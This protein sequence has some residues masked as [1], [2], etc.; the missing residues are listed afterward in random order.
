RRLN[1]I[2][3]SA[4]G[5]TGPMSGLSAWSHS[6]VEASDVGR[7][8]TTVKPLA[9]GVGSVNRPRPTWPRP[10]REPPLLR[11][12]AS[13]VGEAGGEHVARDPHH[14][15]AVEPPATARR[16]ATCPGRQRSGL[17][18]ERRGA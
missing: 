5:A 17:L 11:E 2:T 9:S 10:V 13:V 4:G 12:T 14:R 1:D 3:W 16:V 15:G 7:I 6:T 8:A 18:D